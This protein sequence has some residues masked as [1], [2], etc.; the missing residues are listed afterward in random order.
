[1]GRLLDLSFLCVS[2]FGRIVVIAAGMRGAEYD[3]ELGAVWW[4]ASQQQE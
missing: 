4:F 3:P 1:M 2:A